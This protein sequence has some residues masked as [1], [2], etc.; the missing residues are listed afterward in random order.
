MASPVPSVYPI[1]MKIEPRNKADEARLVATLGEIS[2]PD[3][4]VAYEI[5]PE[6]KE[7]ILN[8][9]SELAL[10]QFVDRLIRAYGI[11]VAPGAPQVAYRETVARSARF[12]GPHCPGSLV[13]RSTRYGPHALDLYLPEKRFLP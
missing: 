4:E 13:P 9:P 8:G 10:D 7:I 3:A 5:D 2:S 1:R 12:P 6:S 11:P